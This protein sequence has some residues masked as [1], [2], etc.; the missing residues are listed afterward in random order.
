MK[1]GANQARSKN[2]NKKSQGQSRNKGKG[3]KKNGQTAKTAAT[4]MM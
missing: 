4:G 1:S 3:S 2:Q